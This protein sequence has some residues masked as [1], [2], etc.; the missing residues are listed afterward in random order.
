MADQ[1][2]PFQSFDL[3]KMMSEFKI[4]GVDWEAMMTSQRRNIEALTNAN[5]VAV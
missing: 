1:K 4:P 5:H 2:N 3:A